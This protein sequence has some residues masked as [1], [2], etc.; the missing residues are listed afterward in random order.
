MSVTR[1]LHSQ[2]SVVSSQGGPRGSSWV[3][4]SWVLLADIAGTVVL[5]YAGV[6]RQLGWVLTITF[7]VL[8]NPVS[9]YTATLMTRTRSLLVKSKG[10]QPSTMGEAGRLTLGG[11]RAAKAVYGA[12]YGFAFLGQSSYL[13]VLGQALQ[14]VFYEHD[15]CL[16]T[17]ILFSCGLC[18][19]FI[20]TIRRLSESVWLCFAN[21][22]LILAVLGI[23]MAQMSYNGR[24]EKVK[25]FLFAED[26]TFITIFG[27]MT[28]IVFSYAG[29]WLYFEIMAEMEEPEHFPRVLYVNAPM[30]VG[31]NLLVACWGYYYAGDAAEGFFLDNLP[32]GVAYRTASAL[33]FAHVL[34]SF[35][36]KNIV[37]T[38]FFH[39]LVAPSRV[40]TRLREPGG[41]RAHGE[42]VCCALLL[43]VACYFA[44]NAVPFFMEFL[45]LMGAV[46]NGPIS[47]I[48][49]MLFYAMALRKASSP[50]VSEGGSLAD[51]REA[52][53]ASVSGKENARPMLGRPPHA[54]ADEAQGGS[55]SD[56][57]STA[58][59]LSLLDKVLFAAVALLIA[60]TLVV[61]TYSVVTQIMAN[62]EKEGPPFSCKLLSRDRAK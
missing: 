2:G 40:S 34:V 45:G 35:L 22:L 19:P 49:P 17:A 41:V 18:L 7:T 6:A 42:Y 16:P 27:A 38:R 33:L 14:G 4:T 61:G 10:V 54:A 46:F 23:V 5:T 44:A 26:L 37:L 47:F 11:D 12:V 56:S 53:S 60:L 30:Q 58:G 62:I 8:L 36:I 3:G 25:T 57:G 31:L 50:E 9:I 1:R 32:N 59:T 15:L 43:L 20:M 48:L 51:P 24:P 21:M 52:S 28:N 29:H 55:R 13:L 39:G